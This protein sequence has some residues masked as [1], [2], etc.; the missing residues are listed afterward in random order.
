MPA[1]QIHLTRFQAHL[2]SEYAQLRADIVAAEPNLSEV[3]IRT[4]LLLGFSLDRLAGCPQDQLL[5]HI[6]D[7]PNDRGIDAFFF[8]RVGRKA[9]LIQSKWVEQPSSPPIS[10]ADAKSFTAG[11]N[12]VFS[13][14]LFEHGNPKIQALRDEIVEAVNTP[15]VDLFPV[16]VSTSDRDVP[17]QSNSIFKTSF[18]MSMGDPDSLRHTRLSDLYQIISPYGEGGGTSIS[19]TLN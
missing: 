7:G 17:D 2:D 4:R 5:R 6:V 8:D 16:L 3:A 13:L 1:G 10:E 18:E 14:V 12:E 19:I 9:F 11:V 15:G